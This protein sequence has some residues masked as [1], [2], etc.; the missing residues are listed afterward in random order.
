MYHIK[1]ESTFTKVPNERG[2]K[3]AY[4][5]SRDFYAY[6]GRELVGNIKHHPYD[7]VGQ[8]TI[9]MDDTGNSCFI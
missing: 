7:K 2:D 8:K 4:K 9:E 3:R 5:R 1:D 6:V